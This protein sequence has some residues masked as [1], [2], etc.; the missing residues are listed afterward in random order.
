MYISD[1]FKKKKV[2]MSF[3]IFPPK[4]ANM[5]AVHEI[6][7][8]LA[9][10]RPDYISVTYGA[11]GS[12]SKSTVDIASIIEKKYGI[13]S[14]AHLTCVCA[15]KDDTDK[16]LKELKSNGV[17]NILAL[18]GDR[19][20]E[21]GDL[22]DFIDFHYASELASY[23]K[24]NFDF[25]LAGGCYP[26]AHP[27]CISLD[28]DVENL[29]LKVDAGVSFLITQLFM[30][31]E[32]F[33]RFKEKVDQNNIRIPIEAGI[34]PVINRKSI[35]KML[36]LSNAAMP[37]K[38]ARILDKFENNQQALKDAGIAYA[39]DQIIDLLANGIDG[40]HLYTMNKPQIARDITRNVH[41]MIYSINDK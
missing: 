38:L 33:Y 26:E 29:K 12:S 5:E 8:G 1:L 11:G 27:E 41:S 23:I 17:N 36:R 7:D 34:M 4:Q 28:R 22:P 30:D 35:E 20:Q 21:L 25:C 19:P 40:I 31:N 3:E 24:D 13:P 2:V 6:I 37:K 18:R 9:V 14:L 39:T 16:I 10:H 15:T 32:Y